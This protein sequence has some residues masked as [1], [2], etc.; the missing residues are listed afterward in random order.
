MSDSHGMYMNQWSVEMIDDMMR[1]GKADNANR[2]IATYIVR[3]VGVSM[4]EKSPSTK[5]H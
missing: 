2:C 5:L 4:W 1:D 3:Y